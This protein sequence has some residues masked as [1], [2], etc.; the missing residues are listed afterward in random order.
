MITVEFSSLR[1]AT[2]V[3]PMMKS[4]LGIL[5]LSWLSADGEEKLSRARHGISELSDKP[6]LT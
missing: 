5:I 4:L 3:L 1:G 6:L 2:D